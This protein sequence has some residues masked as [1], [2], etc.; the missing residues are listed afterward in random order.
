MEPHPQELEDS[1]RRRAARRRGLAERIAVWVANRRSPSKKTPRIRTAGTS[2]RDT[3]GAA[4]GG[5]AAAP[6]WRRVS[7]D[8]PPANTRTTSGGTLRRKARGTLGRAGIH[9]HWDLSLQSTMSFSEQWERVA[10]KTRS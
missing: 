9:T 1:R 8:R 10:A 3:S 4:G 2:G 6:T 5:G 7:Q